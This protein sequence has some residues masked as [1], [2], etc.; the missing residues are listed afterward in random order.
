ML[1]LLLGRCYQTRH[2]PDGPSALMVAKFWIP[3]TVQLDLGLPG[4]DGY[5]VAR[6]QE[7]ELGQNDCGELAQGA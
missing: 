7:N 2:A 5:E 1:S 4:M 6:R 3:D